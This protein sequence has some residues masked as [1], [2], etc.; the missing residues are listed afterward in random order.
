MAQIKASPARRSSAA[1]LVSFSMPVRS[2]RL[3]TRFFLRLFLVTIALCGSTLAGTHGLHAAAARG[4][5][6]GPGSLRFHVQVSACRTVCQGPRGALTP[7]FANGRPVL[8][9]DAAEAD[10]N[11]LVPVG[12]YLYLRFSPAGYQFAVSPPAGI[13]ARPRGTYHLPRNDLGLLTAVRPGSVTITVSLLSG[14]SQPL[15][16]GTTFGWCSL[17]W[18]GYALTTGGPFT[19]ITGAWQVPAVQPSAAATYSATWIG[20]DGFT[21]PSLIQ[22]GTAQ[23]Y[24]PGNPGPFYQAWWEIL[25]AAATPIPDAVAPGD[26]MNAA[27]TALGAG[28]WSLSLTDATQQWSFTS[29][30]A[31]AGQLASAEWIEE[32]PTLNGGSVLPLAPYSQTGFSLGSVNG[33]NPHLV[34]AEGGVMVQGSAQVSTP[35]LPDAAGSGFSLAYGAV[36]PPPPAPVT[37]PPAPPSNLQAVAISSSQI[38]LTWTPDTTSATGFTVTDGT[39][40]W[41]VPADSASLLVGELPPM[42]YRCYE[43]RAYSAAGPGAWTPAACATTL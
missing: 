3:A 26:Q 33:G 27:I 36:S 30:Q 37:G 15:P 29:T 4:A 19:A 21:T 39:T 32:A 42:T 25:P 10:R 41:N 38:Q 14:A 28:L 34:S 18:S 5:V 40:Q 23:N 9:L 1:A 6:T 7:A 35:S 16:C 22:I 11:V 8:A 12:A 20:I 31:Y 2:T 17:N 43:V 13:L 24:I